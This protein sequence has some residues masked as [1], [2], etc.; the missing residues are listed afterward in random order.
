MFSFYFPLILKLEHYID[1][2]VIIYVQIN[3]I[4][5]KSHSIIV[6]EAVENIYYKKDI[7]DLIRLRT[8]Q[9]SSVLENAMGLEI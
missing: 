1:Y 9:A 8:E 2:S 5:Y 4:I 6:K 3:Y 7:L